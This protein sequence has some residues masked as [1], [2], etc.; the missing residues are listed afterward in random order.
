MKKS[1]KTG[2]PRLPKGQARG[3]IVRVR[4]SDSEYHAVKDAADKAG[5]DVSKWARHAMI[6]MAS[7]LGLE[8]SYK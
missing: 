2:R 7:R 6:T 5:N 3:F 1:S 8:S 4:M